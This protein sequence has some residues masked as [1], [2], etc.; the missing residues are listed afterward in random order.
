MTRV[1]PFLARDRRDH[2]Y[3]GEPNSPK[4]LRMTKIDQVA[5][6]QV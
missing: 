4:V 2:L 3:N 5:C 6:Y 1:P